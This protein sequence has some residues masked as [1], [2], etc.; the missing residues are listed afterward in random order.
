MWASYLSTKTQK[1][2]KPLDNQTKNIYVHAY[3]HALINYPIGKNI[4]SSQ[5]NVNATHHL[6]W[7]E[8]PR[9]LIIFYKYSHTLNVEND[10]WKK[11]LYFC[12]MQ[13]GE[14]LIKIK[15]KQN[16]HI[17]FI[18]YINRGEILCL[19][20]NGKIEEKNEFIVH[21]VWAL[22]YIFNRVL[23]AGQFKSSIS[24][25]YEYS[26]VAYISFFKHCVLLKPWIT[27]CILFIIFLNYE[28]SITIL[29][30]L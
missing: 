6:M 15:S 1:T 22:D 16:N 9:F 27:T 21:C 24:F 20:Q 26:Y 7:I 18:Y 11:S 17:L 4:T 19:P 23:K 8:T 13:N 25:W 29:I 28:R 2:V 12:V 30:N 5:I 10:R 3:L 14:N